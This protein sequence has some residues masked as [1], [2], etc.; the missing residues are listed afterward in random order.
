MYHLRGSELDEL[1]DMHHGSRCGKQ[2]FGQDSEVQVY[3]QPANALP[4]A[5]LCGREA[6]GG[7]TETG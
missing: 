4:L 5:F 3:S 1:R 6:G 2:Q 7:V